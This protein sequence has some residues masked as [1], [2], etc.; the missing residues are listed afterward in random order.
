MVDR[1]AIAVGMQLPP[2]SREG[3]YHHWNRFAAANYEYAEHHM[4]D[5]YARREGF[6]RAIGMAPLMSAYMHCMLREWIG[7]DDAT[8]ESVRI[9]LRAPFLRGTTLTAGGVV[10]DVLHEGDGRVRVHLD[11][12]ADSDPNTR[13]LEGSATVV[14]VE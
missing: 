8:I 14:R 3:T 4:D 12:W 9:R 13:L 5:E 1:P 2:F 11:L 6:E 10:K 7:L